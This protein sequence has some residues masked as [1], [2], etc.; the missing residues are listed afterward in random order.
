M[1]PSRPA[2]RRSSPLRVRYT[3]PAA[4]AAVAHALREVLRPFVEAGRPLLFL[5]IGSDRSTG[6]ALGPLVGSRLLEGW[7]GGEEPEVA[8]APRVLGT[9]EAPVHATNLVPTVRWLEMAD[10]RPAVVAVDACLGP[11]ESVGTI[12]VGAGAL[13]PGAGVRKVLPQV[14]DCYVTGT[15]NVGGFMEY[16]VLQN[17][18]LSLVMAMAAVIAEGLLSAVAGLL[19]EAPFLAAE[20]P[21]SLSSGAGL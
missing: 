6:D 20:G 4:A 7:A 15:V 19:P 12:T 11:V 1:R 8:P 2:P 14:G 9:L 13:R 16:L 21:R 10:P 5:C 17:T 3:Q 18:R